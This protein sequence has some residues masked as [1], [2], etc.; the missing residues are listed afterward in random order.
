M[1]IARKGIVSDR[2]HPRLRH[3]SGFYFEAAGIRFTVV[4]EL[5][6]RIFHTQLR[7][8]VGFP[9]PHREQAPGC[10]RGNQQSQSR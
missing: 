4:R 2:T 10:Q 5:P 9:S 1:T 3:R 7:M 6:R 8:P